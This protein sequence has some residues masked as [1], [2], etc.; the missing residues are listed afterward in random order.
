MNRLTSYIHIWY[1][2]PISYTRRHYTVFPTKY[3][4]QL[5]KQLVVGDKKFIYRTDVIRSYE[6][7]PIFSG[8]NFVPLGYKYM[9]IDQD[10]HLLCYNEYFCVVEYMADGSSR[11]MIKQYKN[12]PKGFAHERKQ[13]MVYSYSRIERLK[14]SI[15]YISCSLILKNRSFLRE[16]PRPLLTIVAIVRGIVLYLILLSS[17]RNSWKDKKLQRWQ[18]ETTW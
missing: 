17:R 5:G 10:Y 4:L 12:N 14:N 13:R 11:N 2:A 7:Y 9:L 6:E 3:C 16:S 1:Y 8:E 15:H 18:D